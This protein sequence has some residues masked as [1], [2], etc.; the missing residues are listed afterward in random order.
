MHMEKQGSKN[1]QT[2]LKKVVN[3]A[4]L[5]IERNYDVIKIN[6]IF[7]WINNRIKE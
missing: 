5:Y 2:V 3:L 1:N 6:I 4:L 7:V